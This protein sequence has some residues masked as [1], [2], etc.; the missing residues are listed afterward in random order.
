[1]VLV[2]LFGGFMTPVESAAMTALYAALVQ[3]FVFRDI[4]PLRGLPRVAADCASLVGGFLIILSMALGLTNFLIDAEIPAK[5]LAAMQG[6][7]L[8]PWL[9]LLSL[10]FFLRVVGALMDFFSALFVVAPLTLPLGAAYGIDPAP[11]GM[12]FRANMELGSLTPP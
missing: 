2:G 4:E 7:L 10:T 12:I 6:T 9:S 11:L 1:L 3:C 5:I 8:I